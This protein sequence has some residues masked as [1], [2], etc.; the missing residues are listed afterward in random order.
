M[1]VRPEFPLKV[2]YDGSC[3]VCSAEMAAY[4]RKSHEGRLLFIDVAAPDFNQGKYGITLAEFMYEI[5]VIDRGGRVYRGP[6]GFWAI[7][8]AF[9]ASTW[10]GLLGLLVTLPGLSLIARLAYRCFAR[11]RKYLPKRRDAC[12]DGACRIGRGKRP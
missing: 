10:Y 12:P 2:F 6:E 7:W 9:P 5:H 4:M 3:I 8:Q 11:L 1:P